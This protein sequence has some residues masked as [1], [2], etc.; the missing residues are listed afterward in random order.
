MGLPT[1]QPDYDAAS[2][3]AAAASSGGV[4]FT[5]RRDF[6]AAKTLPK[7][8]R[9]NAAVAGMRTSIYGRVD[10][11][12]MDVSTTTTR[13][14]YGKREFLVAE[15]KPAQ[16]ARQRPEATTNPSASGG[17][18]LGDVTASTKFDGL[19]VYSKE[20]QAW[21]VP[22]DTAKTKTWR[23][24]DSLTIDG[25]GF[26]GLS[27]YRKDFVANRQGRGQQPPPPPPPLT[28]RAA[29]RSGP[30]KPPTD[31]IATP[32]RE[33]FDGRAGYRAEFPKNSPTA[34]EK[35]RSQRHRMKWIRSDDNDEY[36]EVLN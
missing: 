11:G 5:S 27:A 6:P 24:A 16:F 12:E 10:A 7:P 22:V 28:T 30:A 36:E 15:L 18:I 1:W 2:S 9:P 3:E 31:H 35:I 19:T 29:R 14:D 26:D 4:G 20:Y 32:S 17:R 25:G 21:A 8:V 13:A 23:K 34:M 33:P